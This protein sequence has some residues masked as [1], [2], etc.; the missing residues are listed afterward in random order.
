MC[1]LL[2]HPEVLEYLLLIFG[3]TDKD[4]SSLTFSFALQLA[5]VLFS[6]SWGGGGGGGGRGLPLE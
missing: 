3:C 5:P 4:S 1:L 6:S 2:G